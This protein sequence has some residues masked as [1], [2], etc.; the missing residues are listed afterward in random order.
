M[1]RWNDMGEYEKTDLIDKILLRGGGIIAILVVALT[2]YLVVNSSGCK[3]QQVRWES[4]YSY[5]IERK[6]TM[7]SINGEVVREWEGRI[8][9]EYRG[10]ATADLMFFDKNGEATERLVVSYGC[11]QLVV[12]EVG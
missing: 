8:D 5:G 3:R 2:I 6:V 11:G 12:E 10:N 9:V 7:Y 4:E 1:K